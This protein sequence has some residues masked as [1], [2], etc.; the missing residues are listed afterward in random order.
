MIH[1]KSIK[2]KNILSTGNVFT[3][4]DLDKYKTSLVVGENGA[5]KSTMLDALSFALYGKAFRR[6]TK[7]Q[8]SHFTRQ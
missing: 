5:G 2:Y 8:L 1:F 7:N 3:T 6:I 4:I